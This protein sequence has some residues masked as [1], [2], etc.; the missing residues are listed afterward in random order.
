MSESVPPETIKPLEAKSGLPS[1]AP[2]RVEQDQ[3]DEMDNIVPTRG[4]QMLPVVG[5]GGSAGSIPALQR[6]FA[7]TPRDTGMAF[8]VV[9]H[10][11]SEHGSV[12]DEILSR[13]TSMRVVQPVDAE[14][15]EAN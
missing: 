11:S 1:V 2:D 13:S 12:M 4:Y 15:L 9:I 5:L 3:P 7:A 8:V 10:L 6:F 14:K